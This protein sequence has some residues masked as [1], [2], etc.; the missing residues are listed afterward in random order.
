MVDNKYPNIDKIIKAVLA[1][2]ND[3]EHN[4]CMMGAHHDGGAG[5]M[6]NQVLFYKAGMEG[7]LPKSWKKHEQKLDPEY[8]EYLRLQKKFGGK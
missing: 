1:E 2:A 5:T 4:A 6:R 3:A 7:T 8:E